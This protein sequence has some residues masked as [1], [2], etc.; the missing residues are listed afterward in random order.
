[1][2]RD[3]Y[4]KK[5]GRNEPCWC[6][7]G[8]KFKKCH[9][10]R[11]DQPR[12]TAAEAVAKIRKSSERSLCSCPDQWKSACH[13]QIVKAH[14]L[15][16]KSA[17]GEITENGHVY[18]LI[19]KTDRLFHKNDFSGQLISAKKA[20]TFT[21]FCAQH[22]R[23]I[24]LP[25]DTAPFDGSDRSAF[26]AAYRTHCREIFAKEGQLALF[27][28]SRDLDRGASFADQVMLQSGLTLGAKAA[29]FALR[30]LETLKK[31]LD[32]ALL[33]EDFGAFEFANFW[34]DA[35]ADILSAGGFNPTHD[36]NGR[37]IQSYEDV[38]TPSESLFLSILP[39]G[40]GTWA[41]FMWPK[42]FQLMTDFVAGI[43]NEGP[44]LGTVYAVALAFIE[45][46]FLRPNWWSAQSHSDQNILRQLAF[47]GVADDDYRALPTCVRRL[48][49]LA[50]ALA[51]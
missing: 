37:K 46:T 13:G 5:M 31:S 30:E 19:P 3:P 22:D 6:G 29:A 38:E 43:A 50:P 25:L 34:F 15:S 23:E 12:T 11:E 44:K 51:S 42:K 26:L 10:N 9:L 21:G 17:L 7:S 1:M 32:A 40:N 18:S 27:K 49:K 45:N 2:T 39:D 47:M 14:S 20:S 33:I 24:F 35:K 36:I 28:D 48:E 16:R 4:G 8:L 41:S